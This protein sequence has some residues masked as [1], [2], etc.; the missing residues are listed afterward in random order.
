MEMFKP[1]LCSRQLGVH[2]YELVLYQHL[3]LS[4]ALY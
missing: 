1:V 3:L 4:H 2:P